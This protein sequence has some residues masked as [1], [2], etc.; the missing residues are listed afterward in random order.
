MCLYFPILHPTSFVLITPFHSSR[1]ILLHAHRMVFLELSHTRLPMSKQVQFSDPLNVMISG[2]YDIVGT[3]VTRWVDLFGYCLSAIIYSWY[4]NLSSL[5]N[6]GSI[7]IFCFLYYLYVGWRRICAA[8]RRIHS[9]IRA[10]ELCLGAKGV[11]RYQKSVRL[12]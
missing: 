11:C 8:V 12:R 5:V 4:S 7:F 6:L 9:R 2:S 1:N 10:F 3:N